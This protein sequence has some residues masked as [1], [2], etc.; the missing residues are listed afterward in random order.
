VN[1]L[2]PTAQAV[3]DALREAPAAAPELRQR[4]GRSRSAVDK[5]LADLARHQLAVKTDNDTW[6]LTDPAG[7]PGPDNA[8]APDLPSA[9][10]EEAAP[11]DDATSDLVQA[12]DD[13]YSSADEQTTADERLAD[14]QVAPVLLNTLDTQDGGLT[15]AIDEPA[16]ANSDPQGG[17]PRD[18]DPA[19]AADAQ[20]EAL[21]GAQA[22]AESEESVAAQVKIC[23]GCQAQLPGVCPT[24]GSKT[25]SYCAHC[26]RQLPARR[27]SSGQPDILSTGLPKLARGELAGLVENVMRTHPLPDHLGM[28]GWTTGRVA[29]Y[30][31]GRSTGAIGNALERLTTTGVAELHGD[32]PKRY[33]LTATDDNPTNPPDGDGDLL[34]PEN[35]QA[36]TGGETQ[37]PH[38][39]Q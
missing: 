6:I 25:T 23:R 9:S 21:A 35:D 14:N 18:A 26:R 3:L 30:L 15:A 22:R 24:C 38:S 33:Q 13:E 34:P 37:A 10:G 17:S 12:P 36:D 27:R 16:A 5:A 11:D 19:T 20:A 4:L 32:A 7:P 39:R 29:I 31:P 1:T 28:T 8:I 2:T